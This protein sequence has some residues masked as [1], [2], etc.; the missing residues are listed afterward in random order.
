MK[1]QLSNFLAVASSAVLLLTLT[2][3]VRSLRETDQIKGYPCFP[4]RFLVS[5]RG[6]LILHGDEQSY[7]SN[8]IR[9]PEAPCVIWSPS[10]AD[11]GLK[12]SFSLAGFSAASTRGAIV[13][14][15]TTY[16]TNGAT[17]SATFYP[18]QWEVR[19][20]DWAVVLAAAVLPVAT[21]R[22]R[23]REQRAIGH[24]RHCGYDLRATPGR[25]PECGN[26]PT[27]AM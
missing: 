3:W 5:A 16:F 9:D 10:P 18:A 20:P 21:L 11:P 22:R 6:Q 14:G 7:L 19:V 12:W 23:F 26:V 4:N 24:C 27:G 15:P 1:R 17:A 8:W 25:C 13:A 2:I